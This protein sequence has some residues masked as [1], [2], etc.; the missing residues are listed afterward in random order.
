METPCIEWTGCKDEFGRGR[1]WVRNDPRWPKPRFLR[2]SRVSWEE[3]NGPIPDGL[4]VLHKCDNRACYEVEH[5][6]LGTQRDNM[7]D[8]AAKGRRSVK[9]G[10]GANH[11][12]AKL[13][14][15]KVES[16]RRDKRT[17]R[18]VAADYGISLAQVSAIRTGR[19]WKKGTGVIHNGVFIPSA[20]GVAT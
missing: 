2:V 9:V 13:N 19:L 12:M 10:T 20:D 15:A 8:M 4:Y 1:I 16:I 7:N 5:L 11:P 6:F 14:D 3:A 18:E 17:C